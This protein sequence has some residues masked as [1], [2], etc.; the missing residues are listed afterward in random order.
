MKSLLRAR[1]RADPDSPAQAPLQPQLRPHRAGPTETLQCREEAQ[2]WSPRTQVQTA[3]G[4]CAD[5]TESGRHQQGA[6]N[7]GAWR[8]RTGPQRPGQPTSEGTTRPEGG[9]EARRPARMAAQRSFLMTT[10]RGTDKRKT[11]EPGSTKPANLTPKPYQ[12]RPE[13]RGPRASYARV[14]PAPT[15]LSSAHPPR[16]E[17]KEGRLHSEAAL[18]SPAPACG[19]PGAPSPR[20]QL[21]LPR[22]VLVSQG[23]F[24]PTRSQGA[25]VKMGVHVLLRGVKDPREQWGWPTSTGPPCRFQGPSPSWEPRAASQAGAGKQPPQSS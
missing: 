8:A 4:L 22:Q 15:R 9:P 7:A 2:G 17:Q 23:R 16:T 19:L 1:C 18:C 24:L 21:R 12:L 13:G 25:G 3:L 6:V 20:S 14:C 5:H 10:V 11:G